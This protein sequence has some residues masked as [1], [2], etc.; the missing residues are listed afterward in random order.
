MVR[1]VERSMYDFSINKIEIANIHELI[2]LC[3]RF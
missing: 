3:D 1:V 2:L